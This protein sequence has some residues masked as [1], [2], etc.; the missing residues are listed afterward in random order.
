MRKLMWVLIRSLVI[1]FYNSYAGF[2]M[3]LLLFAFGIMRPIEHIYILQEAAQS[4][5]LLLFLM[6][7]WTAYLLMACQYSAQATE[8]PRKQFLRDTILLDG[9]S[10]FLAGFVVHSLLLL[11]IL[12]YMTANFGM[13]LYLWQ[14]TQ[15][16]VLLLFTIFIYLPGLIIFSGYGTLRT[17]HVD[18]LLKL[19]NYKRDLPS[20]LFFFP[21]LVRHHFTRLILTK[22]ASLLLLQLVFL[23][24]EKDVYDYKLML[25][26]CL[27]AALMNSPLLLAYLRFSYSD[28]SFNLGLPLSRLRR[29]T[30][31]MLIAILILIPESILIILRSTLKLSDSLLAICLMIVIPALFFSIQLAFSIHRDK[32]SR[33]FFMLFVLYFLLI[34]YSIPPWLITFSTLWLSGYLFFRYCYAY[35]FIEE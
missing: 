6:L 24:Y 1:D 32:Q 4:L 29:F 26:T 28:M 35:E 17:Y 8:D 11:P 5:V 21:G 25:T 9:Q 10:R 7:L 23:L 31:M 16:V 3:I 34:I 19:S 15:I 14:W 33:R 20:W 2:F 22:A 18:G 27:A 13:A 12:I 30:E